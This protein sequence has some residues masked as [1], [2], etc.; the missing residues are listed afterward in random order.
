MQQLYEGLRLLLKSKAGQSEGTIFK[1][2]NAKLWYVKFDKEDWAQEWCISR[3]LDKPSDRPDIEITW[4]NNN[5]DNQVQRVFD[6]GYIDPLLIEKI[7]NG[8][9]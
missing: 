1:P 6:N 2:Q 3:H 5:T 7:L 4:Y 8:V 9:S